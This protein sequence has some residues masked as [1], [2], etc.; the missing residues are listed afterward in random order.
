MELVEQ[1]MQLG[2][3]GVALALM[4]KLSA[5]HIEH[6]RQTVERMADAVDRLKDAVVELTTWLRARGG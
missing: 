6:S 2:V 4:Y 1:V 5:N 3:A